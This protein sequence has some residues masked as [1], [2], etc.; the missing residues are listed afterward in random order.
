MALGG[1]SY[2]SM[3]SDSFDD[4]E[5]GGGG[6]RSA[7]DRLMVD[8]P[9]TGRDISGGTYRCG[10]AGSRALGAFS[11]GQMAR[12]RRSGPVINKGIER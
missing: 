7:R 10:G 11:G 5:G 2:Y 9:L 6:G 8:D 4:D 1:G 3:S 12:I